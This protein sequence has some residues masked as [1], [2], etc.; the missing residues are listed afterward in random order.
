MK[1]FL[2]KQKEGRITVAEAIKNLVSVEVHGI[3]WLRM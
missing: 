3:I 1:K 2:K